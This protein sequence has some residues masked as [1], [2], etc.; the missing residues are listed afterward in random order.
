M[1]IYPDVLTTCIYIKPQETEQS[2]FKNTKRLLWKKPFLLS[3][4]SCFL[5]RLTPVLGHLIQSLVQ[6]SFQKSPRLKIPQLLS[7]LFEGS[8]TSQS[9]TEALVKRNY[10]LI[11]TRQNFQSLTDS[12]KKPIRR[13]NTFSGYIDQLKRNTKSREIRYKT[14]Y[15]KHSLRI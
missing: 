2:I 5:L 4:Q 6:L 8:Q 9:E 14:T 3:R 7:N 11:K 12:R 1:K 15:Q 13:C 10:F